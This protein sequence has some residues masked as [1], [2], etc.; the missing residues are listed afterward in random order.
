MKDLLASLAST[1]DETLHYFDLSQNDLSLTYGP[2]KWNIRNILV[3]LADAEAV[4]QERIKR[5]IA[6]PGQ[7]IWAF[8]QDKWCEAL[9][10]EEYPLALSRGLYTANRQSII[11]LAEKYYERLGETEFIHNQAGK[12]TLKQ[13]FEKVAS[14]NEGHLVQIRQALSA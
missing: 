9:T 10:Y 6:E 8:D 7:V 4:L 2:G 12:K 1:R 3:H 13:E 5:V 11:Y 14:H